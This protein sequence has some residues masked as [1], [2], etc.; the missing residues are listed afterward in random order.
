MTAPIIP[1]AEPWT[2]DGGPHGAL[3]LHGFTGNPQSMRPLAEALASCGYTVDLPLL[4][5]HGTVVEDMMATGWE[6]WSQAA[7]DAY[8]ALT[9]RCSKVMVAGLSMGGALT[10]WLAAR[11]PDVAGIALVNPLIEPPG[12][13]FRAGIRDLV[14]G[15]T[16]VVDGIGSDIAK[17][18]SIESAYPSTPLAAALSLFEG[19]DSV[20]PLLGEIR[21]PTLLMTSRE[22]HVVS[23]ES[24]DRAERSIAGPVERVWL[25][26]SYHVA[27]LDW[28]A[29]VIEERVVA[30]AGKVLD[31]P[32]TA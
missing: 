6:D 24:G 13:D 23:V 4:P 11:H 18:G 16:S 10:C 9:G 26:R 7:E 15:G 20:A 32:G 2:A 21:C 30:F 19:V 25:E 3:V 5:G 1:G 29:P 8:Q 31:G 14:A 28:D 12:D 22:D 27:T 17:E